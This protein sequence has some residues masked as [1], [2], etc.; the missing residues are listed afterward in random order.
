[1]AGL[2]NKLEV[3]IKQLDSLKQFKALVAGTD[4]QNT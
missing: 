3:E 1:M 2:W 4:E